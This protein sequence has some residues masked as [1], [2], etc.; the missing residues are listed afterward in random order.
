MGVPM[1]PSLPYSACRSLPKQSLPLRVPG[2]FSKGLV[3]CSPGLGQP[4]GFSGTSLKCRLDLCYLR[5]S[6][7]KQQVASSNAVKHNRKSLFLTPDHDLA[8]PGP[9][10][11][12]ESCQD[13]SRPGPGS[14]PCPGPAWAQE[15]VFGSQEAI[16]PPS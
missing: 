11:L 14:G 15:P 6:A 13:Q 10:A 7:A 1:G 3:K 9:Q 5:H 16:G 4:R 8:T 2:G 12:P